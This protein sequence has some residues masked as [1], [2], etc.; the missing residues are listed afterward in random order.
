MRR[1]LLI[2]FIGYFVS[3][4]AEAQNDNL[5]V[6]IS[7]NLNGYWQW[8]SSES[9]TFTIRME[10]TDTTIYSKVK[11]EVLFKYIIYGW[12]SYSQKDSLIENTLS[13][14]R[15]N[16]RKEVSIFGVFL[17]FDK[18]AIRF[19]DI[20][21]DRDFRIKLQFVDK[22]MK[23][24]KWTTSHPLERLMYPPPKAKIWDGQTLPT[25]MILH[26]ICSF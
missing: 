17:D 2:L 7:K 10:C 8:V 6:P 18:I 22:E 12:H 20:T 9:D 14:S 23:T 24:L 26:K 3:V 1:V 16:S 11:D 21:R 4:P 5:K 15:E 25:E 19:H 13:K